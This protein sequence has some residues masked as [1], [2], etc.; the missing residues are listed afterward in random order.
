MLPGSTPHDFLAMFLHGVRG[1]ARVDDQT[2]M[3]H[4]GGIVIAGMVRGND[5]H[6]I[7]CQGF[8]RE[9][10]AFQ[11]EIV[12]SHL[13][14]TRKIRVIVIDTRPAV[15]KKFHDSQ[16]GRLASVVNIFLV[17]DPQDQYSGILEALFALVQCGRYGSP[18]RV[19]ALRS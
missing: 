4:N 13:R 1:I 10:H 18:R 17:G 3:A 2:C 19:R 16:T 14:E 12:F 7:L 8:R 5:D 15:L 11:A 6:V 9:F